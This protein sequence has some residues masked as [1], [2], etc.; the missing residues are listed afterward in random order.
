MRIAVACRSFYAHMPEDALQ[1]VSPRNSRQKEEIGYEG[2]IE[3][4]NFVEDV[5]NLHI[6]CY[7]GLDFTLSP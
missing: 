5:K 2:S 3:F 7:S 6:S 1:G 4:N